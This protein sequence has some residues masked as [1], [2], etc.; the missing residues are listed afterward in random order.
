MS[1][2]KALKQKLLKL[3]RQLVNKKNTPNKIDFDNLFN[4][5]KTNP[6]QNDYAQLLYLMKF[7]P[8]FATRYEQK[9]DEVLKV[10]YSYDKEYRL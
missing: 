1:R 9:I 2:N 4:K 3:E 6:D 8:Y 7:V 5:L 10:D